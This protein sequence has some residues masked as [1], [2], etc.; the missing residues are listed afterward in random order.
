MSILIVFFVCVVTPGFD[1]FLTFANFCCLA[2]ISY[3][4]FN[5]ALLYQTFQG[6]RFHPELTLWPSSKL[7]ILW[8]WVWSWMTKTFQRNHSQGLLKTAASDVLGHRNSWTSE[9]STYCTHYKRPHQRRA[10]MRLKWF[11]G[12]KCVLLFFHYD[13][14]VS[15][16]QK[17]EMQV[18]PKRIEKICRLLTINLSGLP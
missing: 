13:V 1:H 16:F 15:V 10:Q 11:W 18:F 12:Q 2:Y 6:F 17:S 14:S 4:C 3:F 8:S 7:W 5:P 9:K